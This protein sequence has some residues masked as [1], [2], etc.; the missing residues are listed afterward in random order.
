MRIMTGSAFRTSCKPLLRAL[1]ILT[2]PS[3]YILSAQF[4]NK[5]FG[6]FHF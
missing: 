6:T 2:L 4:L 3:Q 5:Q 1:E